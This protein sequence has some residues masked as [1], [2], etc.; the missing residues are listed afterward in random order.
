MASISGDSSPREYLHALIKSYEAKEHQ[1]KELTEKVHKLDAKI[2]SLG[3]LKRIS[4]SNERKQVYKEIESV[5]NELQQSKLHYETAK[6]AL[7]AK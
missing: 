3:P 6:R 4:A 7:K 5:T 2:Q 1:L